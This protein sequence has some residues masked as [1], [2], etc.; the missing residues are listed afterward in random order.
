[1]TLNNVSLPKATG[2]QVNYF[3]IC[4]RKLWLFSHNIEM[5]RENENVQI[6]KLIGEKSYGR[7]RKEVNIDNRIVIDWVESRVL[8]DGTLLIHETKKSRSF[9][10]AHRLQ[11]LYYIYYLKQKGVAARGEIDYPLLKKTEKVELDGE[12]ENEVL[13]VLAG[14]QSVIE[15]PVAPPRLE[16][17]RLC[18]KCAYFELCW[19]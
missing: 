7:E 14:I 13:R 6:G 10:S 11:V 5:E 12:A 19:S 9:D 1:M 17:K 15:M 8:A 16:N 2:T 4:H 3:G 18:E